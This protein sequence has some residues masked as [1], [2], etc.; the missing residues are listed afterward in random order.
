MPQAMVLL[1]KLKLLSES[2]SFQLY[3]NQDGAIQAALQNVSTMLAGSASITTPSVV[4]TAFYPG[5]RSAC[6][7]LW[8]EQGWLEDEDTDH[9][10][11]KRIEASGKKHKEIVKSHDPQPP[12]YEFD[13]VLPPKFA[14]SRQ[15]DEPHLPPTASFSPEQRTSDF[16]HAAPISPHLP[17]AGAPPTV[18]AA[19]QLVRPPAAA[20]PSAGSSQIC[21]P[22]SRLHHSTPE[23]SLSPNYSATFL[24]GFPS[25]SPLRK[26]SDVLQNQN[27]AVP[28]DGSCLSVQVAASICDRTFSDADFSTRANTPSDTDRVPDSLTK[29]RLPS[30]SSEEGPTS[31]AKRLATATANPRPLLLNGLNAELSPTA[32]D[33]ISIHDEQVVRELA[34][35]DDNTAAGNQMSQ[36]LMLAWNYCPAAH[37][38]F[39]AELLKYGAAISS[40]Q[41]E[42]LATCHVNCTSALL[43]HCT[44]QRLAVEQI[45]AAAESGVAVSDETKALLR[46]LYIL[47]PGADMQVFEALLQLSI[48]EHRLLHTSTEEEHS[49]LADS[50]KQ[51]K[52]NI[53]SQACTT[54]GQETLQKNDEQNISTNMLREEV[55]LRTHCA[56]AVII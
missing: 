5:G 9:N 11:Q 20:L 44:V 47:R 40:N 33:T 38:L 46:W 10:E 45:D 22:S 34:N 52:A 25:A 13:D 15:A 42:E 41:T 2:S 16:P 1:R 48:S 36:W 6:R 8:H 50:F 55:K 18:C 23:P 17:P 29:K 14:S 7:N 26:I 24:S 27:G 56:Q 37:Y 43:A 53:V 31:P 35:N 39:I 4:L 28:R 51:H 32:A 19:D 49:S 30:Y 54:L 12:P 21:A 3:T